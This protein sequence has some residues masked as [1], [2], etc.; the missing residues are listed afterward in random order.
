MEGWAPRQGDTSREK[1][2]G[3]H[4]KVDK[5]APRAKEGAVKE[6]RKATDYCQGAVAE[7]L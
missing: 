3:R 1:G 4:S 7:M 5:W 2:K 6:I